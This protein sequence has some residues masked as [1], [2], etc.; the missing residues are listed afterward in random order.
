MEASI[1]NLA[2]SDGF[3]SNRI[4]RRPWEFEFLQNIIWGFE[5]FLENIL[6]VYRTL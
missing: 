5:F 4:K 2:N 3:G 6:K 1:T